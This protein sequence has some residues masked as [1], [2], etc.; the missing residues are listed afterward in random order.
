MVDDVHGSVREV[1]SQLRGEGRGWLFLAVTL[2]WL[3]SIGTRLV[4][5]ALLPRIRVGL[6]LDLTG[7]GL[8]LT[9]L[10]IAYAVSQ[11]PGGLLGDRVG[12]RATLAASTVV[13]TVGVAI[14][15]LAPDVGSFVAGT[16]VFG[17]G[18]GLYST[19]RMTIMSD[20]YPRVTATA[21][22]LSQ[23][24]GNVGTAVLPVVAGL[25]AATA[26]GWRGGLGVIAL[27]FA[28]TAVGLWLTVPQRTHPVVSADDGRSIRTALAGVLRPVPLLVAGMM[29]TMSLVYQGFTSFYPTYLVTAKQL[30]DGTAAALYG[31]FFAT[32]VVVQ[33]LAGAASDRLGTKTTLLAATLVTIGALALL[34]VFDDAVALA[35]VTV[36]LGVQLGF[37]PVAN[38]HAIAVLPDTVQG[39]GFGLIRTAYLVLAAGG[40]VLVGSLADAGLFDEAFLL[41]AGVATVALLL[42]TRLPNEVR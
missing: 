36:L 2:G 34:P 11:F 31:L 19:T 41:L 28:A 20:V 17:V 23:A 21:I 14:A 24:A 29:F 16:V 4:F 22:G 37:W 18:T 8:V 13:S 33:P 30:P 5:P 35:G 6:G 26:L 25:L 3:L 38:A 32:G 7:A 1:V 12:E 27:P 15:A 40:P 9:A 39:S 10:W 42:G